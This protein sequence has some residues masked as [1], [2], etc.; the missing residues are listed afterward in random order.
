MPEQSRGSPGDRGQNHGGQNH[1]AGSEG[2]AGFEIPPGTYSYS[3]ELEGYEPVSGILEPTR[4]TLLEVYLRKLFAQVKFRVREGAT[5]V[6]NAS[7]LF[8]EQY[9]LTNT[10]G[11]VQFDD[12]PVDSTYWYAVSKEGFLEI[13]D[14][15][16]LVND[17]TISIQMLV[18]GIA[19]GPYSG[20][21]WLF[22]NPVTDRLGLH[23]EKPVTLMRI[24][25]GKGMVWKTA[26][27]LQSGDLYFETVHLPDGLYIMQIVY[28]DETLYLCFIKS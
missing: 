12:V 1:G 26:G 11:I 10:V 22:P 18:S 27:H 9:R 28:E 6:Y 14:S 7:V 17:T 24:L 3:I 25:D 5:P 20:D 23:L 13:S 16:V 8:N 21:A 19:P 15:L 4:D 2:I